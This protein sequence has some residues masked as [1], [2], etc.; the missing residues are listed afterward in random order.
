MPR[1]VPPERAD[2]SDQTDSRSH[3][4]PWRLRRA[5]ANSKPAR[6]AG[7]LEYVLLALIVVGVAI[8][9]AMAIIDPSG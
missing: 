9:L 7:P 2:P 8:T 5:S 3:N 4:Q 6:R 1:P